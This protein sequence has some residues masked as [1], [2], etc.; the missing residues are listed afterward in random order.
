VTAAVISFGPSSGTPSPNVL[1]D[2]FSEAGSL[3]RGIMEEHR[4][5]AISFGARVPDWYGSSHCIQ[6]KFIIW[7]VIQT[8]EV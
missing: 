4:S 8:L 3:E 1:K 5:A 7:L 2:Y 6:E